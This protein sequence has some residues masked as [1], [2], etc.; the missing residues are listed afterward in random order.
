MVESPAPATEGVASAS[1]AVPVAAH[2]AQGTVAVH[3][4]G[5]VASA[6]DKGKQPTASDQIEVAR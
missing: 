3:S 2:S 1:Q 6:I 4:E 5:D